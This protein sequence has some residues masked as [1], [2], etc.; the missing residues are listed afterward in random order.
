MP[1]ERAASHLT[2]RSDRRFPIKLNDA[3]TCQGVDADG[4]P[5]TFDDLLSEGQTVAD[6]TDVDGN[7]YGPMH[8]VVAQADGLWVV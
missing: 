6:Y 1:D 8:V 5:V 2:Q 4:R 7:A 3:Y